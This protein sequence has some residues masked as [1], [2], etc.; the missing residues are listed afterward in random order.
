MNYYISLLIF[1]YIVL[2]L[3][4]IYR[5]ALV[6]TPINIYIV[7]SAIY[8][9]FPYVYLIADI[10]VV[11]I[12]LPLLEINSA[13]KIIEFITLTNFILLF[14]LLFSK[15]RGYNTYAQSV[16][17][18]KHLFA[19]KVFYILYPAVFI[20]V[21][22]F[23]WP[24]FGASFELGHSFSAYGKT[25]LL[26]LLSI[27]TVRADRNNNIWLP[28]LL[29]L[30][31]CVVDSARTQLFIVIFMYLYQTKIKVPTMLR[32]LPLISFVISVFIFVTLNRSGI[33]F[34]YE[35]LLWPFFSEAIF[36]SYGVYQVYAMISEGLICY[37]YGYLVDNI[38]LF[39]FNA[40]SSIDNI[41]ILRNVEYANE[42]DI[43]TGKLYPLGGHFFPS[44][45]LIY[46]NKLAPL[47]FGFLFLIYGFL[48]R[49]IPRDLSVL[50]IAAFFFLVKFP[51]FVTLKFM[52]SVCVL[53]TTYILFYYSYRTILHSFRIKL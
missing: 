9:I 41:C 31:L 30:C 28:Y 27:I 32:H 16:C 29:M 44:E 36:G 33:E 17:V 50:Y 15:G 52:V 21:V 23:S 42:S 5:N 1:S 3:F 13:Y 35:Y 22:L 24:K 4:G 37:P 53:Y 39:F 18:E 49:L 12:S 45:F 47:A 51:L 25:S 8:T 26:I 43:F 38:Y 7:F 40:S 20:L 46:F 10:S 48:Y 11:S 14:F 2:F 19:K 34:K 6:I